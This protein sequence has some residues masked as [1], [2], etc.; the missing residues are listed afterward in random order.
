MMGRVVLGNRKR[1]TREQRKKHK[2]ERRKRLSAREPSDAKA[3]ENVTL[4]SY[5]L[6]TA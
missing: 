4:N 5:F 3:E 1:K 2:R 6:L